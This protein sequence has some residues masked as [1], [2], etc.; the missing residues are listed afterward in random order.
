MYVCKIHIRSKEKSNPNF[1]LNILNDTEVC[2]VCGCQLLIRRKKMLKIDPKKVPSLPSQQKN[3]YVYIGTQGK[4]PIM[5]TNQ[6]LTSH[7]LYLNPGTFCL[8]NR[9]VL[10]CDLIVW[11]LHPCK[12]TSQPI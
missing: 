9:R 2:F 10:L 4:S 5:Y 12:F 8:I 1:L 7:S 3:V 6:H 11:L